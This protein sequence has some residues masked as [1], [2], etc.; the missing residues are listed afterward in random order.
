MRERVESSLCLLRAE[1]NEPG[2]AE[3]QFQRV[4]PQLLFT[5]SRAQVEDARMPFLL[6]HTEAHQTL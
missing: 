5:Q 6:S 2:E 1:S 4:K 3:I